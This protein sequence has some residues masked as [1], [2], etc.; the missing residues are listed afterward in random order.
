MSTPASTYARIPISAMQSNPAECKYYL[1][2]SHLRVSSPT[3][4]ITIDPTAGF[5]AQSHVSGSPVELI[6]PPL[7][8]QWSNDTAAPPPILK[9]PTTGNELRLVFELTGDQLDAQVEVQL[10]TQLDAQLKA[11]PN[12]QSR[13]KAL[14]SVPPLPPRS[15]KSGPTPS[16]PQ[17]HDTDDAQ[18]F[19][20][21]A[22][23][24]QDIKELCLETGPRRLGFLTP[25]ITT[26]SKTQQGNSRIHRW[27][28]SYPTSEGTSNNSAAAGYKAVFAFL[29]KSPSSSQLQIASL[30]GLWIQGNTSQD[31]PAGVRFSLSQIQMPSIPGVRHWR[32]T[33]TPEKQSTSFWSKF[34]SFGNS[35]N[36][37]PALDSQPPIPPAQ[38]ATSGTLP[39]FGQNRETFEAPSPEVPGSSKSSIK[40]SISAT[41]PLANDAED[42]P[43]FRATVVEYENNIRQMKTSTKRIVKAAQAVLEARKAWAIAEENFATELAGF[44]PAEQL[45]EKYLRPMAQ[46]LGERSEM[47]ARQMQNLLIEPLCRFQSV[48]LK[49]AEVYRKSFDEESKEYYNFLSKYMALKQDNSLQKK[50]EVEAR[51]ERRRQRFEAKRFEYW[52]FLLDMR[53][54]GSKGEEIFQHITNYSERHCRNWVEMGHLADEMKPDLDSILSELAVSQEKSA[55]QRK[56]RQD[57]RKRLSRMF[58]E[59]DISS[60][61]YSFAQITKNTHGVEGAGLDP[62]TPAFYSVSNDSFD[63]TPPSSNQSTVD[64]PDSQPK[65]EH[66]R[67]LRLSS[68]PSRPS[69][70]APSNIAGIRDLEHQDTDT[71]TALGR[72]KEG[73]LFATSKPNLHNSTVLDKSNNTNW[74]KYWCVVSEGHLHE[75]SHWK[76]GATTLHNEPINLRIS[77]VRACR[78]Q[79]RRFCFEVITPKF[80]RVYQATSADDMNSWI[81]VISNAIQGLL[82]GTSSCRNLNLQYAN[83]RES[84][85]SMDSVGGNRGELTAGL[86]GRASME[87][88]IQAASLPTSLQDRVQPGQAVGRKRGETAALG[89]NE[90]GQIISP[91]SR[92]STPAS[93]QSDDDRLGTRL[94]AVMRESSPANNFCADCG[95]KNPDW[96]VINLGILVCIE[97]SGIHRSLGTHISKVRSFTLDTTSYTRDLFDFIRAVGNNV[98]NQI[99]EANLDPMSA[100]L[101]TNQP[102]AA[103]S[104]AL[105]KPFIPFR[106]PVVND[107]REYKASFIQKKY[108]DRAFVDRK[109]PIEID[110]PGKKQVIHRSSVNVGINT[111]SA[112]RA[113]FQSVLVNNIPAAVAA[114]AAGAD[115]NAVQGA[116]DNT[117]RLPSSSYFMNRKEKQ[118]SVP[119]A[120]D[121]FGLGSIPNTAQSP[122]L[123]DSILLPVTSTL[124]ESSTDKHPDAKDYIN[125]VPSSM[126]NPHKSFTVMQSTP[127]LIAL[128]HG[129]PFSLDEQYE[130]FPL[131]E[132]IIQ[133]G[134]TNDLSIEAKLLDDEN[135]L[136]EQRTDEQESSTG[137]RRPGTISRTGSGSKQ[138][139]NDA[140]THM[141]TSSDSKNDGTEE[142]R[143][144]NSDSQATNRQNVSH[145]MGISNNP[146]QRTSAMNYLRAKSVAR[147]DVSALDPSTQLSKKAASTP[148]VTHY[149]SEDQLLNNYSSGS[150]VND[151]SNYSGFGSQR[152]SSPSNP[153]PPSRSAALAS[154]LNI[155]PRLRPQ[156]GYHTVNSI[157]APA[158]ASSSPAPSSTNSGTGYVSTMM[159]NGSHPRYPTTG[160]QDISALFQKRRGSDSGITGT[161]GSRS[162]SSASKEAKAQYRKSG[163]FSLLAPISS[164]LSPSFRRQ[165]QSQLLNSDEPSGPNFG[166]MFDNTTG[167]DSN[168]DTG[169]SRAQKVKATLTK[170]LR[171]SSAYSK[172]NSG[173]TNNLTAMMRDDDSVVRR[174]MNPEAPAGSLPSSP[175]LSLPS[176]I[177]AAQPTDLQAAEG[178]ELGSSERDPPERQLSWPD[179][180]TFMS[181]SV[182]S[183]DLVQLASSSSST[184]SSSRVANL[185]IPLSRV[186]RPRPMSG[187]Y[188]M[189]DSQRYSHAP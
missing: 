158:S 175:S 15:Q 97:C 12:A 155:S 119:T 19:F 5:I 114:F 138:G 186:S 165:H 139:A 60:T 94:L 168:Q 106:K 49:A 174:S 83:T 61:D 77:T 17:E 125:T 24:E 111:S 159:P 123:D 35:Q 4:S 104:S 177:L 133:N 91:Y 143:D 131:A 176:N 8:P 163:D 153:P 82:S 13:G 33:S 105:S 65:P 156:G 137:T 171:L 25:V 183:P 162:S 72:R 7:E 37:L 75:Y 3:L 69:D 130:V 71:G 45:V 56:E 78:N 180:N 20:T 108:V 1:I 152:P 118:S 121:A 189:L 181:T 122:I 68:T 23:S 22:R 87:Q 172:R 44:K 166:A 170:S 126:N 34:P 70:S 110:R 116:S 84:R 73:F 100:T 184:S 51:Y 88:M 42:G 29:H 67:T 98:S 57:Q 40:S 50:A 161:N 47:L 99:W 28:W 2:F 6:E 27:E 59:Q 81:N 109:F 149:Q 39:I 151:S 86:A 16:L 79:D 92:E 145:A 66:K 31:T 63:G 187:S 58:D 11:Q 160:Q 132:F 62:P 147:G 117:S 127:L 101:P 115:L 178:E 124:T 148:M 53:V 89:L 76:K 48:D 80:K 36:S 52:V 169:S 157:S 144:A 150:G 140:S 120:L 185:D 9:V 30:F 164:I 55:A 64:L 129:L 142:N 54:G 96:C 179:F 41:I 112:T 167:H 85:P 188:I 74:R 18:I 43:L 21:V 182:S 141:K 146:G 113:L 173:L 46:T 32:R 136:E 10:D 154:M 90:M 102:D 93:I 128:R 95:A 134:A 14:P 135:I 26:V 38:K 107:S 103:G